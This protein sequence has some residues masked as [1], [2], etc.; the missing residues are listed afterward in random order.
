MTKA[1]K[2]PMS[3]VYEAMAIM[4][5]NH[6]TIASYYPPSGTEWIGEA[7]VDWD[8]YNVLHY[9]ISTAD[10][11][12]NAADVVHVPAS[13]ILEAMLVSHVLPTARVQ[14]LADE[15][16]RQ[17]R[18]ADPILRAA[19][20]CAQWR[21]AMAVNDHPRHL[22]RIASPRI[23]VGHPCFRCGD[24]AFDSRLCCGAL[25]CISCGTRA[26]AMWDPFC[27]A[28][29]VLYRAQA[30][31]GLLPR[32]A[33]GF[34]RDFQDEIDAANED[35]RH[36]MQCNHC[37]RVVTGAHAWGCYWCGGRA[38]RHCGGCGIQ[39]NQGAI[40]RSEL[41]SIEVDEIDL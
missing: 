8:C 30:A 34:Y 13:Q 6:E 1:H 4:A 40:A 37:A 38:C 24:L 41:E 19:W 35:H 32:T 12:V 28:M 21:K 3:T 7:G 25:L 39:G 15:V 33:V 18:I 27:C 36:T 9:C 16:G 22:R 14:L 5:T 10:T 17:N 11:I 26:G 2:D 20:A 29:V 31:R 23:V